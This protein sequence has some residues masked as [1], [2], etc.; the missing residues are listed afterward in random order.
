VTSRPRPAG[1]GK[2]TLSRASILDA[3]LEL[4]DE[5]GPTALSMRTLAQRLGVTATAI[6]Y[7]Y[8]GREELLES[9]VDRVCGRIIDPVPAEGPW[10]DRLRALMSALVDEAC[11]HPA[12]A[13]WTIT[14]YARKR[15]VLRI[16]E[17]MLSIL[18][19]AG[20][21]AATAMEIKG[22]LLRFCVGHLALRAAADGPRWDELPDDEFPEHQAAGPAI[23]AFDP[24]ANFRTGID[25]L[26]AGF[27]P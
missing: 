6:Y 7:H 24:E 22:V 12:V 5:G 1:G 15:P 14:N 8:A 20:F 21:D 13:T 17:L 25:I 16:H 19:S 4:L 18:R 9:V 23:D 27:T 11:A 2:T 3:G 10:D 26:L